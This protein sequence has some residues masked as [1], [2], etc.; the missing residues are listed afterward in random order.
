MEQFKILTKAV[1]L[2]KEIN[3]GKDSAKLR[4]HEVKLQNEQILFEYTVFDF[5]SKYDNRTALEHV[6]NCAYEQLLTKSIC[7]CKGKGLYEE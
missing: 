1:E 5:E 7:D 4:L 3:D 2:F 6:R